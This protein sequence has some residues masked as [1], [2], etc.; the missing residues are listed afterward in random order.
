[1]KPLVNYSR[2]QRA[3]LR[4]RGRDAIAVWGELVYD[5]GGPDERAQEFRYDLATRVITLI[6]V[7]ERRSEQLDEMGVVVTPSVPDGRK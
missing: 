3:V 5:Q 2:W 6:N 7:D 1:M 4:L